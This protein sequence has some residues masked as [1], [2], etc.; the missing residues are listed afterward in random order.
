MGLSP[1]VRAMDDLLSIMKLENEIKEAVMNGTI[2][3]KNAIRLSRME[4]NDRIC[5]FRMF[6]K[7][8]MSSSKQ[9]EIIENCCDIALRDNISLRDIAEDREVERI[10]EQDCLTL[11]QKG[12]SIRQW[13]R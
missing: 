12:D 13:I 7:V 2:A 11:S 10:L 1:S 8:N 3:E 4:K 6:C 9:A 5:F